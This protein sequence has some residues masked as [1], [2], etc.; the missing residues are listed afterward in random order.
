MPWCQKSPKSPDVF[1]FSGQNT[2]VPKFT[3][4]TQETTL[5]PE[6]GNNK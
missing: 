5:R 2:E 4:T 3:D 1:C 6:S